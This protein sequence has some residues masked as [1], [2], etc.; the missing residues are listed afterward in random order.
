MTNE[1]PQVIIMDFPLVAQIIGD[2]GGECPED[3]IDQLDELKT[4]IA[5]QESVDQFNDM[6]AHQ[7][8]KVQASYDA[9]INDRASTPLRYLGMAARPA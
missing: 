2:N 3:L 9:D 4:D 7:C 1:I 6:N 8:V 5:T